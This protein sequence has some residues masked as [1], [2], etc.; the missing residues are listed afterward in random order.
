MRFDELK[1][2][3]KLL[4]DIDDNKNQYV[5]SVQKLTNNIVT[6]A[7]V[8]WSCNTVFLKEDNCVHSFSIKLFV[9][10]ICDGQIYDLE[11]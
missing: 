11:R 10:V 1:N 8:N 6:I 2:G 5:A 9:K 3:Y 4:W 7:L